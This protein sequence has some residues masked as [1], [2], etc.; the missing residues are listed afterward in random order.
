MGSTLSE[1]L[2]LHTGPARG[3][4]I[5]VQMNWPQSLTSH[6]SL[7]ASAPRCH[8]SMPQ[9]LWTR[10]AC[11]ASDLARGALRYADGLAGWLGRDLQR[12]RLLQQ[13]ARPVLQ[14]P[15]M[16]VA[17][18]LVDEIQEHG[19]VGRLKRPA[20]HALE[21]VRPACMHT[22]M[23]ASDGPSGPNQIVIMC[24]VQHGVHPEG[25]A[26]A[27]APNMNTSCPQGAL[28]RGVAAR[29]R[30]SSAGCEACRAATQPGHAA[31]PCTPR[32]AA[33]ARPACA[34]A[35]ALTS[36]RRWRGRW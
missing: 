28:M 9:M 30:S 31:G 2:S 5:S 26:P 15:S 12:G 3:C 16:R 20:H 18:A 24:I 25:L 23:L 35:R 34:C 19:L 27:P 32:Y 8:S 7:L 21:V 33:C 17:L 11:S 36:P 29:R 13:P 1:R 14:G 6:F 10:G 22:C 4:T